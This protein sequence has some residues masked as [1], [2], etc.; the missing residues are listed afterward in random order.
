VK[1]A[2]TAVARQWL[3]SRSV[4]AVTDTRATTQELLEAVFSLNPTSDTSYHVFTVVTT[5]NKSNL[6]NYKPSY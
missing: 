3:S 5:A 4:M 6:Q 1:P 2:E